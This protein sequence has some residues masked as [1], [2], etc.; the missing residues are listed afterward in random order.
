[1]DFPL[2]VF[3]DLDGTLLDHQSYSFQGAAETL[4]RLQHFAIPLIL[5]SSKTRVELEAVQEKLRLHAPFIAE[6]GGGLFIP[7]D[8]DLSAIDVLETAGD[9]YTMVFG[10]PYSFIREVFETLRPRYSIQGFGDMALDE[11][12][13][14]TGLPEE[15][16]ERARQRDFSEP[17]IFLAEPRLEKLQEEAGAHGLQVVR[18][19]RFFHLMG[20]GQDK[21]LAV[22]ATTR[23]FQARCPR[24]ITTVG[25]GD[26][27]NDL[28]MLRAVDIPVLVQKPDGS[29]EETRL[30][31]VRCSPFPGSRGWGA[32]MTAI[33]DEW[34]PQNGLRY[35]GGPEMTGNTL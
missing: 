18:G 10:R 23:L 28:P 34:L 21:G 31:G 3:T 25:L 13:A 32:A 6:N 4:Q 35:S 12:I 5:T 1:M 14:L 16:A 27:A 8:Y 22:A 11:I 9:Y 26:A 33:L 7:R 15:A 17:F 19:G 24:K 20:A 2:L 29:F 30:P